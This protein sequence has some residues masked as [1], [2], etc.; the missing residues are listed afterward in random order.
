VLYLIIT[1]GKIKS[2]GGIPIKREQEGQSSLYYMNDEN[3]EHDNQLQSRLR[4]YTTS[5]RTR[6][7]N[8]FRGIKM[9]S[10]TRRAISFAVRF[11]LYESVTNNHFTEVLL[12]ANREAYKTRILLFMRDEY[13]DIYYASVDMTCGQEK[14]PPWEEAGRTVGDL[15]DDWIAGVV[16]EVLKTCKQKIETYNKYLPDFEKN[17]DDYRVKITK[18]CI[19]KNERYI[20]LLTQGGK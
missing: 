2:I 18:D 11:P 14:L 5:M 12:P 13:E 8:A 17:D 20:E 7:V 15:L 4:Q 19:A 16:T 3:Q 6:I 9:C 1:R 10:M